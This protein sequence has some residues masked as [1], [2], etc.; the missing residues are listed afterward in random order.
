[1][2]PTVRLFSL[3]AAAFAVSAAMA[4]CGGGATSVPAGNDGLR[5]AARSGPA[6][7]LPGQAS[8]AL[9]YVA[10]HSAFG[11]G[12]GTPSI[13]VYPA[14]ANGDATPVATL[15]GPA[16]RENQIQFVAVDQLGT[17][18]VSN[19]AQGE[20]SGYV[21][22]F[23]AGHQSG[24]VAPQYLI[25][26][27]NSPEGVALG[28]SDALAVGTIDS[29]NVYTNRHGRQDL[30]RSIAG[31]NTQILN[32]Y[33]VFS[34]HHK[35]YLAEQD[36]VYVFPFKADGNVAPAQLISGTATML[37]DVLGVASDSTGAIDATNLN[38]DDIVEFAKDAN[39]DA[40]PTGVVT[41]NAFD[42][43]WGIFIDGNDTVYVANEGN[44]SIAIFPAGTLATGIPSATISGADTGLD[45]PIGVFVR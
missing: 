32:T 7:R 13:T 42:Q 29:V 22:G 11:S 15:S 1:M 30:K 12:S 34:A 35:L 31:S 18:W 3:S 40:V 14:S 16:T 10:N 17:L 21:T 25:S 23:V 37:Q 38:A 28:P 27:L 4:G 20:A 45:N 39:G 36:A 24:N 9:I 6:S 19:V 33:E 5:P 8:S 2:A 44:N 41:G 43:P 26:G